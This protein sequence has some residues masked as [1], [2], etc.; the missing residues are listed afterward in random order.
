MILPSTITPGVYKVT[1]T[2]SEPSGASTS[3]VIQLSVVVNNDSNTGGS[4]TSQ[5]ESSSTLDQR[6]SQILNTY[7]TVT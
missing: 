6:L 4:S 1:V 7:S 5:S 2:A 3:Q